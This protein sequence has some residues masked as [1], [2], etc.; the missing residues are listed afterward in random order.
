MG[1]SGTI[2]CGLVMVLVSLFM[3][4]LLLVDVG[5]SV[6]A[7][8]TSFTSCLGAAITGASGSTA[9]L[10]VTSTD[11]LLRY[12]CICHTYCTECCSSAMLLTV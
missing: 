12:Y 6:S 1:Y 10:P 2:S 5:M 7:V 3:V 8:G 11:H 9:C 4:V